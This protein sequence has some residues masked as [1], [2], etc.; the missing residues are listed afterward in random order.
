MVSRVITRLTR[1]ALLVFL[2][3][4]LVATTSACGII[5][6]GADKPPGTRI[7]E[8]IARV[9]GQS[10]MQKFGVGSVAL[11]SALTDGATSR[12]WAL[13]TVPTT[14]VSPTIDAILIGEDVW[15]NID[16]GSRASEPG[17]SDVNLKWLHM[18]KAKLPSDLLAALSATISRG[19]EELAA[20]IVTADQITDE[21]FRGTIDLNLAK[22]FVNMAHITVGASA[23][24]VPFEAALDDAGNLLRLTLK[25]VDVGTAK[26]LELDVTMQDVGKPLNIGRPDGAIEAP[27][28]LYPLLGA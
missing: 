12:V 22:S 7:A 20:A 2:S 3:V 11:A 15:L 9:L 8:A 21:T 19:L 5:G 26:H 1:C 18:A 24:P 23:Q 28:T 27:A 10:R 14:G 4:V 16:F 25:D 17:F 13:Y 6:G